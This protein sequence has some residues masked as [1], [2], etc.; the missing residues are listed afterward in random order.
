MN[1]QFALQTTVVAGGNQV[2]CD[3]SGEA[4]I[5]HLQDGIY[6]GLNPVGARIW[7]LLQEPRTVGDITS[8]ILDEYDVEPSRCDQDLS[9]LLLELSSRKLIEVGH[10]GHQEV[11]LS[12]EM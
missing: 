12:P 6:Y 5:L 1:N 11:S 2:S 10:E 8:R 9:A 7:Q 4:V 3:L